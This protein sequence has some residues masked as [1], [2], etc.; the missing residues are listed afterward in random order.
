[1]QQDLAD[2]RAAAGDENLQ[3]AGQQAAQLASELGQAAGQHAAKGVSELKESTA[4]IR[5]IDWRAGAEQGSAQ[6][7]ALG[8]QA[9]SQI[10]NITGEAVDYVGPAG[11]G[12]LKSQTYT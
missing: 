1:M 12:Y 11:A 4:G 6:V 10:S 2:A 7:E 8:E 9:Q 3:A 5:E